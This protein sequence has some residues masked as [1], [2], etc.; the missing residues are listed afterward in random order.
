[1]GVSASAG[2]FIGFIVEYGDF[3]STM[4]QISSGPECPNKHPGPDGKFC[5]ECGEKISIQRTLIYVPTSRFQAYCD[6]NSVVPA[7]AWPFDPTSQGRY[8]LEEGYDSDAFG[9]L[10]LECVDAVDGSDHE[11][12]TIAIGKSVHSVHDICS[13]GGG[14]P[15]S[16]LLDEINQHWAEISK[17]R[18][19]L[20]IDRPVK[21]FLCGH[22]SY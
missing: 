4:S 7:E 18:A 20:G 1:M 5:Q 15:H 8:L 19:A 21:M 6:A 11:P 10:A 2:I 16:M 17:I 3:W 12:E 9:Y 22:C 13:N 14:E